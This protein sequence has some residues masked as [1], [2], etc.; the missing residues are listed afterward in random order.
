M[1]AHETK[2]LLKN[3]LTIQRVSAKY[4]LAGAQAALRAMIDRSVFRQKIFSAMLLWMLRFL[5]FFV[6]GPRGHAMVV[7]YIAAAHTIMDK[8]NTAPR[9]RSC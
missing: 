4:I 7:L 8:E 6:G 3:L 9:R 1:R 2:M 5:V